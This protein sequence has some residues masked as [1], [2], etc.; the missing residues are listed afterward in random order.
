MRKLRGI[1][2]ALATWCALAAGTAEAAA[3]G[4]ATPWQLG[5][6]GAASPGMERIDS[7]H[8]VLLVLVTL[9]TLFVLA[10]LVYC[11]VRFNEKA[12]PTPSRTTHHTLIEVLWTVIPIVILVVIAVPSF[13]LLYLVDE[14]PQSEMT[15]KAIGNAWFWD[16]EYPD[17]GVAFTA[18]MVRDK[19]GKPA[20]NPRLL[21]TDNAVVVP[22]GT[23][24]RV[25]VTSN[26]V[27]HS[28][29]MPSLGV[30]K[31]AVP[32]RLNETWFKATKE[33]M[34]YGQ[35]SELCGKDHGFMPIMMKVV[36]KAEFEDW[37]KKTKRADN[38][39]PA[40]TQLAVAGRNE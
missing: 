30:K 20:G 21:E 37:V 15:I 23:T 19:D 16:Y 18:N 1:A 26:D 40:A 7:F 27:I 32:G 39:P 22:V 5:F 9:I 3:I 24:V 29:A 38:A 33:G 12:N 13:K 35:C 6:Q 36:S 28:W 34:Y 2:A 10:L 11:I 25:Q 14:V 8:D 4:Q 17:H 31:D